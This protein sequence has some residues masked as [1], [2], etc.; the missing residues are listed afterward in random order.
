MLGGRGGETHAHMNALGWAAMKLHDS[1]EGT[2]NKAL[3]VS[4]PHLP[5]EKEGNGARSPRLAP[6]K[7][8]QDPGSTSHPLCTQTVSR[9][10]GRG[11][12]GEGRA[13]SAF[14]EMS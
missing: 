2:P 7:H 3:C 1:M 5:F 14:S 9:I 8:L 13:K 4:G 6:Y 10:G 12:P 11:M